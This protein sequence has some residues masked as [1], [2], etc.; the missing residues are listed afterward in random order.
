[1]GPQRVPIPPG[2]GVIE[3]VPAAVAGAADN[4]L[5]EALLT[6]RKR[7]WVLVVAAIIGLAYGIFKVVSEPK[8][9]EAYGRIEVRTGSSNEYRV[10]AA[11]GGVGEGTNKLATEVAILSSDS[12]MLTVAREM[13]LQDNA[14][15]LGLKPPI[16]H[17]S[18]DDPAV[19][20]ATIQLLQG[21]LGIQLVPKTDII[22]ISYTSTNPR[23]ATD[24]VNTVIAAYMH[25]SYQTR[26]E[27]TQRVSQW[28]Q[29]QL[30]D[31]KQ[32]VETSQ[33]TT[34]A[35]AAAPRHHRLRSESQPDLQPAR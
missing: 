9:Y 11:T 35:A 16:A 14:D 13:K 15:F 8:V 33:E 25:R 32:Q 26:Y 30:D 10:T 29:G 23:L 20:E 1:M 6:L 3:G 12:L 22:R 27:S 2:A 28:L 19:R 4:T 24:I 21:T 7:K 5:S 17:Q 31:L 18:L 34:D